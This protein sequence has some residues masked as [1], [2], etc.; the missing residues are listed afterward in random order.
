LLELAPT[1]EPP[2]PEPLPVIV[3]P[4]PVAAPLP[5]PHADEGSGID[6]RAM[7]IS[8]LVTGGVGLVATGFGIGFGIDALQKTNESDAEC[9]GGCTDLGAQ[10][11]T[12]AVSAADASTALLIIG[13]VATATG[14]VLVVWSAAAGDAAITAT[15][16]GARL[17]A[18]W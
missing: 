5:A 8:G 9:V 4:P 1:P 11:S 17:K 6:Y 2:P 7:L 18:T 14:I 10:R 12:E 13:G 3:A 15:V 16:S